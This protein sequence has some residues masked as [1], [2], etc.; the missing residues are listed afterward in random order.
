MKKKPR[1][2]RNNDRSLTITT[3]NKTPKIGKR[4]KIIINDG[5]KRRIL[6][7]IASIVTRSNLQF[8][9]TLNGKKLKNLILNLI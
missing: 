6:V 8:S 2:L 7:S 3:E 5:K 4:E 9:R 1:I